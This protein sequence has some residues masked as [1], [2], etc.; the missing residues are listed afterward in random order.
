LEKLREFKN[1]KK[2][3]VINKI[4]MVEQEKVNNVIARLEQEDMFESILAIS[5]KEE[6]NHLSVV[7]EIKKHLKSDVKFYEDSKQFS[8][9]SDDFFI[10]ELIREKIL[11]N[12][13]EEIPHSVG[14]KVKRFE[15]EDNLLVIEA[16][17]FVERD[18]QKGIIIG[19]AGSMLKKIGKSARL[20]LKGEYEMPIFLD[21]HVKV[22]SK[23]GQR[24][25]KLS[26]IGYELE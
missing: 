7:K 2:I 19:R 6:F 21:L 18:S 10:S 9:Y 4:D 3:A 13:H 26:E 8:D 25:E 20:E 1:I 11:I 17:I 24:E 15:K 12:T 14:V 5:L 23:W 16:D 22:L